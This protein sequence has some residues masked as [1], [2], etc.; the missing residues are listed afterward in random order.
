MHAVLAQLP[1]AFLNLWGTLAVGIAAVSVPIII[2]LLNRRRFK[3]VVWAAMRFLLNAQKQ[4]TRRMRL[5][6]LILLLTRCAIVLLV[7]L[8]MASITPWAEAIWANLGLGGAGGPRH[9]GA[10]IHKIIVLDGSLSMAA[11]SEGGKTCFERGKELALQIV[12]DSAPGDG[13]SLVLMKDVPVW[14][15]GEAA[16]EPSKVAREIEP[17]R[18][19]HGNANVA[20]TLNMVSAKLAESGKRFDLREVYFIT[21]M[22]R[23][24]WLGAQGQAPQP[25]KADVRESREKSI[26]QEIQQ[27]AKTF[28]VDV[29]RDGVTNVAVTDISLTDT[30]IVAGTEVAVNAGVHNFGPGARERL[31]VELMVG[32]AREKADDPP[33]AL[34]SVAAELIDLKAGD[35]RSV[36]F[37]HRFSEPGTYVVQVRVDEDELPVD[38]SRS[39]VITVRKTI[40]VMLVNGKP[41]ADRFETATTLL[42]LAL[43]PQGSR[44]PIQPEEFTVSKF[45]DV[46]EAR[47]ADFDC[48]FLCDVSRLGDRDIARLEAHLRRGGGLVVAL[49]DRVADQLNGYNRL[50]YRDGEG[51]LPAQLKEVRKAAPGTQFSLN[52]DQDALLTPP[53]KAFKDE[54]NAITLRTPPFYRYILAEPAPDGRV[55]TVLT[56]VPEIVDKE[57]APP[58]DKLPDAAPA[59]LEW[60]PPLPAEERAKFAR[61]DGAAPGVARPAAPSRYRG[62]VV[63]VTSTLNLDWNNWPISPSYLAMMQELLRFAVSGKLREHAVTVGGILEQA[64]PPS[65]GDVSGLLYLPG[66]GNHPVKTRIRAAQEQTVFRW[67]DT[68]ISGIYRLTV[69]ADPQEHLF[70]VN[71]PTG[72][73]EGRPSESDL[74]R[75]SKEQL[76]AAHPSWDFQ[77]VT[78]LRDVQHAD[79]PTGQ[80][81]SDEA[82]PAGRMGPEV[83]RWVLLAVLG[84]L[85]LEVVL[86]WVFGHHTAVPGAG[87]PPATGLLWP[88]LV[89]GAALV[90]LVFVAGSLIHAA[91]TGDFLGYLGDDIRG[92]VEGWMG[93]PP[94]SPGESTHWHLEFNPFLL[95]ASGDYWLSI[96]VGV[97]ALALV[98]GIYL[99]EP[100]TAGVPYKILLGGLR[101]FVVFFTLAVLLPQIDLRF[102]RQ[103][104]PDVVLLIDDS[105]SMG[106]PDHYRDEAVQKSADN[107]GE[108]VR[109]Q[110]Q[111]RLPERIKA[112]EGER[113]AAQAKGNKVEAGQLAAR[114]QFLQAQLADVN[115]PNW[116]ASRLQL[117]QALLS[118]ENPDWI[119]SLL[120]RR[121]M[122]VHI[123]HLDVNGRLVKLKDVKGNSAG[124]LTDGSDA[125]MQKRARQALAELQPT[126]NDSRLG[127]AVRQVLDYY[128][129]ASLTAVVMMTDGVTTKDE[130]LGQVA[131]YSAQRGVPLFFVGIGD[132]HDVRDL[133]LHDLQ[134]EDTVYVHDRVVFEARLTGRG[135][136][137]LT[138]P[139]VLK[140]KEKNGKERELR[141][142]KVRIDPRGNPVKVQLRD[143]PDKPGE[144]LYIVEVEMPRVEGTDKGP[145][146]SDLRLTRTVFV[147]ETKKIKVLYI[148]GTPRY[149]FRFIK[150][151]L[152]REA[153][154]KKKTRTIELKVLLTDADED[155]PKQDITAIADFPPTS[156]ELNSYDVVILGDVDPR[157]RKMGDGRMRLLA[158]FVRER[159]GGLLVIA[160][161][162]FSPHAYKGTPLADVLPV[163]P[164][165][166]PAEPE[167]RSDGFRPDLTPVGRRHPIFRFSPDDGE[168]LNVWHRLAPMYWW[169]EGYRTKPLAE[170][171]ASHPKRRAEG[172]AKERG[173]G[174]PLVVQHF[175]GAGRCMFFGF[176][177]TWRWRF[178]ED[179]LRFN[180]FWIQTVRYLSRS[181]VSRTTLRLDRQTPYRVGEPIKVTVQFPENALP[182]RKPG[183]KGAPDKLEV[184]VLVEHRA[185]PGADGRSETEVQTLTLAKVEGSWATYEGLL[186][187]T[188]E[189]KYKFTL[190]NPDVSKQ[191]PSGERPSAEAVVVQPPGEVDRLR[192]NL[193]ELKGAAETTE[194]RFYTLATADRLLDELPSGERIVINTPLPPQPLWNHLLA[195]LLVLG[196]LASEWVLRKRKHLL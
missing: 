33:F 43:H 31:R 67:A 114:A 158:D 54:D 145:N 134:V 87:Q 193:D 108:F 192:M 3:V 5:E 82:A 161:D 77:V 181:R 153:P 116:R 107:L 29:G 123:F 75:V 70:A 144:K 118:R 137:D 85:L 187:R 63:L 170:V 163:E 73:G 120:N 62:K 9:R 180:Q 19:S 30:L 111:E 102:E 91:E 159:G 189:G 4:N 47:L 86:A 72:G 190:T 26:V 156:E 146:P 169:S 110:M 13:L 151:L 80:E 167:E 21:D 160:G 60:N 28:F 98:V 105:R 164:L 39:V 95:G 183:A 196:L 32:R 64:L 142:T 58:Q 76:Q 127:T 15:V 83:A 97:L 24:T 174:H 188:R 162:E 7:V 172:K 157:G 109:K 128:R 8:A 38:D 117:A 138:V 68:D 52:F 88:G 65:G 48:I 11:R 179:E 166:R 143:Q 99:L 149:E 175:V 17:L 66:Q 147:Q 18:Q 44:S 115:S 155:F 141:R 121:R 84:L 55:R 2:H 135:Y 195:F 59:L 74:T 186:V 41:S 122:K 171:L 96:A 50:L 103:G 136:K 112:L 100:R 35:R 78:S 23:S 90:L 37:R 14:V 27:R 51:L 124:E 126:G 69:G 125:A 152:E 140:V 92:V 139:V 129:G 154:G 16:L 71:V 89:G 40:P 6:Q 168:N 25:G 131:E 165:A 132:D 81:R 34:R 42:G 119:A 191:Q 22:Q 93:I 101:L 130:T 10:R 173:E 49:G 36:A 104:W 177:E 94:P 12:K 176:D 61:P 1:F 150:S 56:F 53:L 20:A 46:N 79:A 185:P 182:G 113:D 184:K 133:K 45:A 194:G 57:K 148:E 106:V 178:R